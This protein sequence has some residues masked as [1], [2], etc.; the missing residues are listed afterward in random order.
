MG[1]GLLCRNNLCVVWAMKIIVG[2]GFVKSERIL[3]G[4]VDKDLREG[5]QCH[6]LTTCVICQI[7]VIRIIVGERFDVLMT[8]VCY[9]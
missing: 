3:Y 8:G 4:M 6:V 5:R 9:E 7:W 2:G 1:G